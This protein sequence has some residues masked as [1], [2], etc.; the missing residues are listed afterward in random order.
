MRL[1]AVVGSLAIASGMLTLGAQSL[2]TVKVTV[3]RANVRSEPSDK[4][5]VVSQV[6]SGTL[7]TLKAIEG[8]WFKVQLPEMGAL[9]VEAYISRKVAQIEKLD[10]PAAATPEPTNAGGPPND[11]TGMAVAWHL[12]AGSTWLSAADATVAQL[13]QRAGTM[14]AMAAELP[15]EL[16]APIAAGDA[17]VSYVWT[18]AADA[19]ARVVDD[20]RPV[21]IVQFKGVPGVSPDDLSAALVRLTPAPSGVRLVAMARGRADEISRTT[22]EWDVMREL[23]QELVRTNAEVVDRGMAPL[24]PDE[25]LEPGEYAV[26][27][28]PARKRLPGATVLSREGEGRLFATAWPFKIN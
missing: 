27:A 23:R 15:A 16:H 5:P 8:D 26:V 20:R 21:F 6:T 22:P 11:K 28:R 9:R 1:I 3:A 4:A 25:D 14:K 2:G 24:Q 18:I 10:A 19:V 7:L 13:A 17:Q 12:A